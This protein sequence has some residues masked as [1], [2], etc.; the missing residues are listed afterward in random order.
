MFVRHCCVTGNHEKF[1]K[2]TQ[3]LANPATR[4]KMEQ[5]RATLAA[6]GTVSDADER[7]LMQHLGPALA[8]ADTTCPFGE[9]ARTLTVDRL[10]A[11]G[12]WFGAPPVFVTLATNDVDDPNTIRLTFR[13][14][15]AG[16]IPDCVNAAFAEEVLAGTASGTTIDVPLP[17]THQ[18]R[19]AAVRGNPVAVAVL[20]KRII[21]ALVE[22]LFGCPLS[23]ADT[24]LVKQVQTKYFKQ[25]NVPVLIVQL[26]VVLLA[27]NTALVAAADTQSRC[28]RTPS[29]CLRQK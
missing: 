11:M 7:E 8:F 29:S 21:I 22:E 1:Q 18:Q 3:W 24:E 20:Y 27:T 9:A 19:L 4:T 23:T 2:L 28:L 13:T 5:A 10:V 26:L 16:Q 25:V 17:K 6:G 14:R 12:G 15:A